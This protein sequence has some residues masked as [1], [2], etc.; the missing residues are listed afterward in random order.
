MCSYVLPPGPLERMCAGMQG[1]CL[2]VPG[3][4]MTAR[5][6]TVM[7]PEGGP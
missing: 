6:L 5:D 2:C 1:C 3:V 4:S 7:D